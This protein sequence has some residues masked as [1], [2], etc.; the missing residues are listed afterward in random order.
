MKKEQEAQP[1][2]VEISA[3][4]FE[5]MVIDAVNSHQET[6]DGL[7]AELDKAKWALDR[8]MAVHYVVM[9]YPNGGFG[10]KVELEDKRPIGFKSNRERKV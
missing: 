2:A 1:T 5:Q 10:L 6:I 7:K 9:K 4:K 3:D 8:N